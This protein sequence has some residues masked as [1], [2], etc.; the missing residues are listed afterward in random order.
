MVLQDVVD[1][2][3]DAHNTSWQRGCLTLFEE[4]TSNARIRRKMVVQNIYPK[5][6]A[7][8]LRPLSLC[9]VPQRVARQLGPRCTHGSRGKLLGDHSDKRT[10]ESPPRSRVIWLGGGRR[11]AQGPSPGVADGS[12]APRPGHRE[13]KTS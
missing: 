13:A 12:E 3:D 6:D 1:S 5:G 10:P 8:S 4:D 9:R 7:T 11:Q 2:V